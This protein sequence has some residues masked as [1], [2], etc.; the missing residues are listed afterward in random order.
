VFLSLSKRG[1]FSP[2]VGSITPAVLKNGVRSEGGSPEP[3][4]N[5]VKT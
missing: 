2:M 5:G 3:P 4:K 1:F